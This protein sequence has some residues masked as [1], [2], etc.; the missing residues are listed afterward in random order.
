MNAF[1]QASE[2]ERIA[3]V[4]LMPWFLMRTERAD[5]V[6]PGL[7]LQKLAGDYVVTLAGKQYGLE[8]KAEERHT[9][10]WYL[11]TW[12]NLPELNPGWMVTSRADWLAYFF[13]DVRVLY[14]T[15]MRQLQSWAFGANGKPGQIYN[16]PEKQQSKYAQL[17]YTTGRV[18]PISEIQ[19]AGLQIKKFTAE[20]R[21]QPHLTN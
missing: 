19:R 17:N 11:E 15:N 2:I 18:V 6:P 14:I 10:N 4:E 21:K 7:F 12:S 16:Y 1:R 20:D 13:C 8:I 3:K 9:G 5:E